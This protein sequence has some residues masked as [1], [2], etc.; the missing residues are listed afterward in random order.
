[1]ATEAAPFE[2]VI[3][4][5]TDPGH[6]TAGDF[7]AT[8]AWGDGSSSAGTITPSGG[9]FTV[10]GSHTYAQAGSYTATV[11]VADAGG[12]SASGTVTVTVADAPLSA[13]GRTVR[14]TE[15]AAGSGAV[16]FFTDPD[17]HAGAGQFTAL[18]DWGD[19]SPPAPGAVSPDGP[20]FDVTGSHA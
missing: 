11:T 3:A 18:I 8:V 10:S 12:A 2:G 13:V 7:S 5:F 4:S 19:G 14:F 6:G 1:L 17:P 20:G 16:A 9:G 15:A